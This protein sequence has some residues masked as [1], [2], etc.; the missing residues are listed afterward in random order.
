MN[1]IAATVAVAATVT[2]TGCFGPPA[3]NKLAEDWYHFVGKGD[4]SSACE[5]M[6]T[7]GVPLKKGSPEH[8]QC[9]LMYSA[10]SMKYAKPEDMKNLTRIKVTGAKVKGDRAEI[11]REDLQ[12]VLD[13]Q[14]SSLDLVRI[15]G[16][17]YVANLS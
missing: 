7:N 4:W 15:D 17:W 11:S 10:A 12:G 6:A 5:R 9:V 14:P 3:P 1:R 16:R 2:M 13:P 8:S